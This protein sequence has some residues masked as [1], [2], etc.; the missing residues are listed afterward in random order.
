[1]KKLIAISLISVFALANEGNATKADSNATQAQNPNMAVA[2]EG[3]KYIKMLGKALKENVGKN[4]KADPT[5][6][7]AA[8]FCSQ[9]AKEVAQEVSKNFPEN[10]KVRRTAIKYRNPKSKPDATDLEV[11]NKM[12]EALKAKTLEKK[13]MV[14]D[15][16][17]TKR[18][19]VPLIVE[20]ACTK[21]HGDV[22]KMDSK[23]QEVI[24]KAYPEDKAVGFKEGDL[25]GAVVAEIA[26][27]K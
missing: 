9:K 7:K 22:A 2:K 12:D 23:V 3:V 18:V 15:V 6:L 14:V 20:K 25:R 19:Y 11:L 26:P 4:L 24:K 21:C 17:G 13:P 16:N 1:M 5:G 10:I 8:E 27:K